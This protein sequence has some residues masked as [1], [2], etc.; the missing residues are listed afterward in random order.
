ML[1]TTGKFHEQNPQT[2]REF[3]AA[4]EDAMALIHANPAR[5]AEAYVSLAR[6]RIDA[7][8]AT[9]IIRTLN[10]RFESTPRGVFAIATFM[11][12]I[13]MIK[14]APSRWQDMFF[15]DGWVADGS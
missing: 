8:E 5:A 13:G 6:E 10:A 7:T 14:V 2:M 1:W 12:D 9:D 11:H 15:E 3:R 4:L